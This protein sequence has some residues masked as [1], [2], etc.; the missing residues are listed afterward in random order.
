MT[1]TAPAANLDLT[2]A[3]PH[4]I[5]LAEAGISVMDKRVGL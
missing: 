1:I 2:F 5:N 4:A 3:L